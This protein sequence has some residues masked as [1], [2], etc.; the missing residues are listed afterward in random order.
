MSVKIHALL[1]AYEVITR[2]YDEANSTHSCIAFK[3]QFNE[4]FEPESSF[5][6]VSIGKRLFNTQNSSKKV[7]QK[8][9]FTKEKKNLKNVSEHQN[10]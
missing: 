7:Y 8:C 4:E 3:L 1:I 9:V 5:K 6:H 2:E 10:T